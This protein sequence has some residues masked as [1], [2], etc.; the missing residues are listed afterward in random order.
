M[1]H[2]YVWSNIH[3]GLFKIFIC[4]VLFCFVKYSELCLSRH[5]P[6]VSTP[7]PFPPPPPP[8]MNLKIYSLAKNLRL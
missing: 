5:Q 2:N 7:S 8:P 1:Y 6:K 3:L 4:N